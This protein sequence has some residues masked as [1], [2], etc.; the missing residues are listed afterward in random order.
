MG[1]DQVALKLGQPLG[2]NAGIG[3][4]AEAGVDAI[5][6][7]AAG[8]DSLD[9]GG[10]SADAV[11]AGG[12]EFGGSALP[13]LAGRGE[14]D[15]FGVQRDHG[16]ASRRFGRGGTAGYICHASEGGSHERVQ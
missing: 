3:E 10:G 8:N 16:R 5:D 15:G 13:E 14:V 12:A 9:R 2:G 6:R 11:E 4:Q 1:Q 7:L